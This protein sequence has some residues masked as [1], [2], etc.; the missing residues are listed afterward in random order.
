MTVS[1]DG[2]LANIARCFIAASAALAGQCVLLTLLFIGGV[3]T[4]WAV[5]PASERSVLTSLYGSTNGASWTNRTNWNGG[6]GTECTWFG[7]ICDGGQ[8]QVIRIDLPSNNLVGTLP[9]LNGL[10][11]LQSFWAYGNQLTGS[12]PS[13]NGLPALTYFNV[14]ANKLSGSIPSL[15]GLTALSIFGVGSN[16]LSGSIPS[17]SGLTALTH[18]NISSNQLSGSIPSLSGL[19]ALQTLVANENQL[20][21]SIPSLSGLPALAYFGVSYNQ[22]SGSI[23]S[24]S[25]LTTLQT[26]VANDNQL[27]G[28]IPSLGGLTALQTFG[29][30][31]NQLSGSIPSLSGLSALAYFNVDANQLSGSIPSLTGLTALAILGVGSNQLSGSIPSLTGLP[32]LAHFNGSSNQLSG[33][34]PSLSGLTTLQVLRVDHNQLSGPVP[35]PPASLVTGF[36]DLCANYLV[37]SGNPAVDA[38]W[39]TAAGNWLACQTAVAVGGS[40]IQQATALD[41]AVGVR[42]VPAPP[43]GTTVSTAYRIEVVGGPLVLT[44]TIVAAS[45]G[46]AST[47]VSGLTNGTPYGVRAFALDAA[48][49]AGPPSSSVSVTPQAPPAAVTL[50]SEALPY[51]VLFLHGYASEGAEWETVV[52]YLQDLKFGTIVAKTFSDAN[53]NACAQAVEL[54]QWITDARAQGGAGKVMLVGH[55]QGG[56]VARAY[57]QAGQD[58]RNFSDQFSLGPALSVSE[59]ACY[60]ALKD[61]PPFFNRDNSDIAGLIT[62]GTPHDGADAL[63]AYT[64]HAQTLLQPGSRFLD[65]LNDFSNFPLPDNL[66]VVNLIG[67]IG[68]LADDD[69]LV[70]KAS[71]DMRTVGYR[72]SGHEIRERTWRRHFAGC[73]AEISRTSEYK[74]GTGIAEAIGVI[75]VLRIRL[76]SP[77]TL[78]VVDPAGKV[79]DTTTR[80]IWGATYDSL[81]D[82]N[83]HRTD[84]IEIPAPLPG[85]YEIT[86]IP[87]ATAMAADTF[88]LFVEQ[89]GIE[90]TVV[91][92]RPI[93]AGLLPYQTIFSK[94]AISPT[95]SGYARNYVQKAYVA[96]YGRPG[97][98][99]GQNYWA[100][101]MDAEGGSLDAIIGA[102]GYSDEFNR[103]YGGLDFVALV[104]KIYQQA[105]GRNPEQGGLDYY[106]GELLAGRKTLQTI[107]LDVLNGA[108]TAPDSTVV[109]NKLKVAAHY[110]AQV[111]TGCAYGTE[112]DGLDALSA[113]TADPATVAA[114]KVAIDS[115]CG[116]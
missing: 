61:Q 95:G 83:G 73:P 102:F 49:V 86:V 52:K 68:P 28:S 21:G 31:N 99:P 48:Q 25:G 69:C 109:T 39:V 111:A 72:G 116:P 106:V 70:S 60:L 14:D 50:I 59:T 78:R 64:G 4:A 67:S 11:A 53:Q 23:P 5:I 56:L 92:N 45:D 91:S 89:G 47:V 84:L 12:I 108:T 30:N 97:D 66:P 98:P 74:D 79:V 10:T 80:G 29:A 77:A 105:L 43:F 57:M 40:R 94:T 27:S 63:P 75:D 34:I 13:L 51:P 16:Q 100:S 113:V 114:A 93:G 58:P 8:G 65:T 76:G 32:A 41:G 81:E 24:L 22:L 46:S 3:T 115:R 33:S 96:Y 2:L 101:R 1:F 6:V 18:F 85:N 110:T 90:R 35:A 107:T 82:Q 55:S 26:L 87:D 20:S 88:S 37:S 17:L 54:K 42:L 7:V 15:S 112:Q 103:R 38:A 19:T 104:T 44:K 9:S 62:F 36:A 71:Q